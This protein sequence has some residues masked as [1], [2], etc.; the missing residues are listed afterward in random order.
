MHPDNAYRLVFWGPG[1]NGGLTL[2]EALRRPEFDVVGAIVYS[3][4]KDGVDVG[5]LVGEPPV[6]IKATRDKEA[7]FE[8][9]ADCVIHGARPTLDMTR[10]DDDVVRLLE[11]GKNVISIVQYF[12]PPMRG[13]DVVERL[14]RACLTGGTTLH[15]SGINPGFVLE[16]L[17]LTLTGLMTTVRSIRMVEL[18]EIS[19]AVNQSPN[20]VLS[21]FGM[22]LDEIHSGHPA[23]AVPDRMYR[24]MIGFLADRLFDARPEDVRIEGQAGGI[25]ASARYE[26]TALTVEPGKAIAVTHTHD[27]YLGDHRFFTHEAYWYL[28]KENCPFPGVDGDSHYIVEIDGDPVTVRQR[29]DLQSVFPDVPTTSYVTAVPPLQ[30]VA[31]VC[32]A[33]PGFMYHDSRPHWT[34]DYRR[35]VTSRSTS[36]S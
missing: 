21:G 7:I 4:D 24:E 29:V 17:V 35:L 20:F 14:E 28:G 23:A 5:E 19:E 16:R 6:G 32:A 1:H 30:A 33:E 9:D 11:S 2:K 13:G 18:V 22:D 36:R 15:G 27:A 31:Q 25:A 12:Y 10:T 34:T 3:P 8:L 26:I